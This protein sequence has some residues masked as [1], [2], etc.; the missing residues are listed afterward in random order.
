MRQDSEHARPTETHR[1]ILGL[2]D[3]G[4]LVRDYTQ[5]IDCLEEKVGLSTDLHKGAGNRSYRGVDCV[6][7]ESLRRLRCSKCSGTHSRD[8]C[9]QETETLAGQGPPC[10]GYANISDAKT[11]AKKRTTTIG[12]LRP[13]VVPYDELDP[14]ADSISA[15]ARRD[16][17]LR[18]DVLLI[19]G[20][21][22]TTHGVKRLVKDFAKVIHKRAGKVVFVTS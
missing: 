12:T 5:N 17:L 1:F 22:L 13:D 9:S 19:L 14:R 8:E 7:H 3:A 21:S 16:L 18:P 10:P 6:L 15:I 20:T 2:R 4:K 11:T